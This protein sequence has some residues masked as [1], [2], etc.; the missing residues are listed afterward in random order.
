[1]GLDVY[2]GTLTRYYSDDWETVWARHA[3]E[4]GM[5]SMTVRVDERGVREVQRRNP[6]EGRDVLASPGNPRLDWDERVTRPYF[7]DKPDCNG[8]AA[9]MLHAAHAMRPDLGRPEAVPEDW[10][11]DEAYKASTGENLNGSPCSYVMAPELWLPG[12]SSSSSMHGTQGPGGRRR[13]HRGAPRQLARAQ[14]AN[15]PRRS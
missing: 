4:A 13:L 14:Q 7:T 1:M 5:Q 15:L 12:A 10:R 9:L 8:Y 2:A 3:R 6:K 11:E